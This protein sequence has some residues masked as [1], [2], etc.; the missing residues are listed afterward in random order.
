MQL[1]MV[2]RRAPVGSLTVLGDLAQATGPWAYDDW[3]EILPLPAA[4]GRPVRRRS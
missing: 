3:D 1:R 4:E 2:A